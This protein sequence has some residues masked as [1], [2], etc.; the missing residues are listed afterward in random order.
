MGGASRGA[1]GYRV[2]DCCDREMTSCLMLLPSANTYGGQYTVSLRI[3]ICG[4]AVHLF[5]QFR[6][7]P[8]PN[9]GDHECYN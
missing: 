6:N 4:R 1:R 8:E 5:K 7:E 2:A 9:K 3:K